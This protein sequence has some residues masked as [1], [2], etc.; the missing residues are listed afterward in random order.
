MSEH[1]LSGSA[2]TRVYL[3]I[4]AVL[5]IG[6]IP[7]LAGAVWGQLEPEALGGSRHS[8]LSMGYDAVRHLCI[9]AP[10]VWIMHMARADGVSMRR[11]GWTPI[12][13]RLDAVLVIVVLF[14]DFIAYWL[15]AAADGLLQVYAP[16]LHQLSQPTPAEVDASNAVLPRPDSLAGWLLLCASILAAAAAEE[17]VC[18][19]YLMT[20]F[21]DLWNHRAKALVVSSAIFASYH[22]YQGWF[23]LLG[24]FLSG[25]AFGLV[26]LATRRLLP[27]I[28]GHALVNLLITALFSPSSS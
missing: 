6:V 23:A 22:I 19:G 2:R 8:P 7:H 28:I 27:I 10:V 14:A 3:E 17:I 11:F 18:R 24:V 12:H 26:F 15:Y 4:G 9:I 16:A 25:M 21:E 1:E 13:W 5:C 20:R